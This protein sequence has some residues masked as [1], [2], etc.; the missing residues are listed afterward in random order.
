MG[1][2]VQTALKEAK[3][4]LIEAQ[5]VVD[6]CKAQLSELRDP[7]NEKIAELKKGEA[8]LAQA[9]EKALQ[10]YHLTAKSAIPDN[11]VHLVRN[12]NDEDTEGKKSGAEKAANPL[13]TEDI[14]GKAMEHVNKEEGAASATSSDDWTQIVALNYR[15]AHA[16]A[17]VGD[18]VGNASGFGIAPPAAAAKALATTGKGGNKNAATKARDKQIT[19]SVKSPLRPSLGSNYTSCIVFWAILN[20]SK[21]THT[22]RGH[23]QRSTCS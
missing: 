2:A 15:A 4:E 9:H 17:I 7:R 16:G 5:E 22:K 14:T 23:V 6:D 13:Q 8:V 18:N 11:V 1:Q 19:N 20:P 12:E 3:F 21:T 10:F